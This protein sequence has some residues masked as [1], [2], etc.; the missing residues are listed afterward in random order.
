MSSIRLCWKLKTWLIPNL[1]TDW[2]DVC[3]S[4][5]H[6]VMLGVSQVCKPILHIFFTYFLASY[7]F[8]IVSHRYD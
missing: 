6:Q 8:R 5:I 1:F 4:Y 3:H 7:R 2:H